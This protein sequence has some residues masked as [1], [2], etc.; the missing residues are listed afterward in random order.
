M[1]YKKILPVYCENHKEYIHKYTLNANVLMLL[2][3]V[4]TH[5]NQKALKCSYCTYTLFSV[6]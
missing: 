2:Q 5:I 3:L 1:I 4:R 6:V